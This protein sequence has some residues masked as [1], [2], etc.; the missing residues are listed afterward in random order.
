[1]QKICRKIDFKSTWEWEQA[2]FHV[3]L[4]VVFL[5]LIYCSWS[6]CAIPWEGN[7]VETVIHNQFCQCQQLHSTR[8]HPLLMS[9]FNSQTQFREHLTH[10]HTWLTDNPDSHTHSTHRHTWLKDIPD[11][12]TLDSQTYVPDSGAPDPRNVQLMDRPDWLYYHPKYGQS[13]YNQSTV[14]LIS[15]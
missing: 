14:L 5:L 13:Q 7:R 9:T 6:A 11:T 8:G 3:L 12:D 15:R 4:L 10:G 2:G 1:M